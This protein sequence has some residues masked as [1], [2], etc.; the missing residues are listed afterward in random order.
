MVGMRFDRKITIERFAATK[1]ELGGQEKVWTEYSQAWASVTPVLD[2]ERLR[3]DT[4]AAS[5]TD[6]FLIKW[7]AVTSGI[8][9]KD[10]ISFDGRI[11]DIHGVKEV[12]RRRYIELSASAS[13]S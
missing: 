10:R 12:G 1:N 3:A 4:T 9:V 13:V 5:I 7:N 11:F 2:G 6:R 8:G